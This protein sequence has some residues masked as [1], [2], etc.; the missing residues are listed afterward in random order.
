MLNKELHV[1]KDNELKTIHQRHAELSE[2][3][4][5]TAVHRRHDSSARHYK[6]ND[7]WEERTENKH[8]MGIRRV[9]SIGKC[10]INSE[11]LLG[12]GNVTSHH[13]RQRG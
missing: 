10:L 11:L 6:E 13:R 9:P 7:S 8:N 1:G 4:L 12:T 5:L 3:F 2:I